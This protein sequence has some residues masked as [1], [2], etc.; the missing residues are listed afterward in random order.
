MPLPASF[1]E[2][3][4]ARTP[5][6][7]L[8]GRRVRLA[9]SGKQWKGCCPFHGE[10]TPSF[11][12]Y[13]DGYHC[14]GC[15]AHGDAISFVMQS[16]GLG[17]M[18]A[19]EQLAGEAGLTVPKPTP[20]ASAAVQRRTGIT[21]VLEAA[22]A[23]YQRLLGLPEGRAARDYL[24]GRG[25]QAETIA[26]FGLGWAGERGGLT[27]QL[28]RDGIRSEQL[29]EAGLLRHDEE[30]DRSYEL[31]SNRVMFP[32]LDRRGTIISFG[33]R[34]LGNGQPKYLNG[35][36]T[37]VFAK[38]RN[39]YGLNRARE[40]VRA[41]GTLLVVEGY[42]DV[43]AVSQAGFG[44]A[45]APLGTALT[46]DQLEALWRISPSPM[47]CFDGDGAGGRAATRAME[48]ALPMLT[49][50]RTMRFA[51]LPANQDPDSLVRAGGSPALQTIL[52]AARSPSDA[53]FDMVRAEAGSATPEQL[54]AFRTRLVEAANRINDKALQSEY[55]AA[56]LDKFYANRRQSRGGRGKA[57]GVA[58]MPRP[59]NDPDS[60]A[61]E[62]ARILTAILLRHPLLFHDVS[63][64]FASLTMTDE[65]AALR[66]AVEE[67]A[68]SAEAL[69]SAVLID[70]LN[71]SGFLA[72]VERVLAGTPMPLPA[73]AAADAMPADAEA[74]WWHIFGFLNVDH[75]Q[76]EVESAKAD[77]AQNLTAETMRRLTALVVAWNKIRSGEPDGVELVAA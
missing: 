32:I 47:L 66:D 64:A 65:L 40:A 30:N 52:D 42:M 10:K 53:L 43:I 12:V 35:P 27:A 23:H 31:F 57:P 33:G 8:I 55:R 63:S 39:L 6:S 7:V 20:E 26:Q 5:L 29:T 58:H 1:I 45:V 67:W 13:E 75:L 38:R 37:E 44:G 11:Y 72:S 59:P 56:L 50:E 16:Q 61:A 54:A 70:H 77:A 73:C 68:D 60:T 36:D 62:R 25:L 15:G 48:L 71:A 41:G 22:Q 46:A 34:V 51:T 21:A 18:D 28:L 14:F 19:V 76:A 9:R 69:D 4:S 17:F 49:P 2:E 24:L 74:G 3:L